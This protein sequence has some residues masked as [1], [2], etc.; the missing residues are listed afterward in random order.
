MFFSTRLD[1]ICS[2]MTFLNIE[3]KTLETEADKF[4]EKTNIKLTWP[5]ADELCKFNMK[6][7]NVKEISKQNSKKLK[8]INQL[9]INAQ[10]KLASL[11][12]ADGNLKKKHSH[13][14][15]FI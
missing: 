1:I 4:L 11:I 13:S 10:S 15:S 2:L 5:L 12:V 14:C 3:I 7:I 6:M 9:I 8:D